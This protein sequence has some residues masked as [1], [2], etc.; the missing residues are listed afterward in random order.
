MQSGLNCNA[1]KILVAELPHYD[2][3]YAIVLAKSDEFTAYSPK[4]ILCLFV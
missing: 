1:S 2:Y 3:T 4:L